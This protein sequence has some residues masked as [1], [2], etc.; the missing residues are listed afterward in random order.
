MNAAFER[1]TAEHL[2]WQ[3]LDRSIPVRVAEVCA[4]T[5]LLALCS[6]LSF[7]LPFTPV[8][9]TMQ[10]FGVMAIA[11][12]FGP[13]EA[14]AAIL[15]YLAEGAGG[16]PVFSPYGSPGLARL[17]GPTAGFLLAYPFAAFAGSFVFRML[18]HTAPLWARAVA[19]GL[20]A[21]IPVFLFGAGWLAILAQTNLITTWHLAVLPFLPGEFLKLFLLA[22]TAT[23]FHRV[24][25]RQP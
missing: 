13:F 23:L 9:I 5:I 8:P 25:Q 18:R 22:S 11:L 15:L 20:A 16:F 1:D 7:P 14:A 10:T 19:A 21:L 17:M 3:G 4:A 2:K 12:M 6:H 24:R